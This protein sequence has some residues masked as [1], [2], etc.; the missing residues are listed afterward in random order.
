VTSGRPPAVPAGHN[1]DMNRDDTATGCG[2]CRDGSPLAIDFQMAFQ[3]IVNLTTREV[4]A[5]E[6]LVRGP[7]GEGAGHVLGQVNESNRYAFDQACRVRAIE[8]AARLGL[9]DGPAKLSIN[10]LP[11]AVYRPE[12]CIQTTLKA[13]RRTG[14]PPSKLIFEVTEGEQI[15]NRD[16]LKNIFAAYRKMGFTTAI[17]DFGA[18]YAGLNL[19]AEFQPDILKVDMELTRRIH[20]DVVRQAILKSITTF[21]RSLGFTV[22]AEGIESLDEMLFLQGIGIDLFQGHFFARPAI[23]VLPEPAWPTLI[24]DLPAARAL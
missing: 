12:T 10:F 3:P 2:A 9:G 11:N 7:N 14:F 5:Y 24:D 17:D 22:V 15:A 18:G 13:A 8:T 20:G 23:G 16:H 1:R 6:A 21:S 4:F 19:L